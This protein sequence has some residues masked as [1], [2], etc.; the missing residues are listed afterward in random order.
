MNPFKSYRATTQISHFFLSSK[1]TTLSM[2][3]NQILTRPVYYSKCRPIRRTTD[4][5]AVTSPG[6]T[7]RRPT[8]FTEKDVDF[9]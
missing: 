2:D 8:T 7:H 3:R 4:L 1:G 6:G 9:I 5:H